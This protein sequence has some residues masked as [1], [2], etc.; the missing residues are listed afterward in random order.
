EPLVGLD[1]GRGD[2]DRRGS[3]DLGEGAGDRVAPQPRDAAGTPDLGA[4]RR[5][6]RV[7]ARDRPVRQLHRPQRPDPGFQS[8]MGYWP[9]RDTTIVV[10]TNLFATPAGTEPADEL[11]RL[12]IQ[13]LAGSASGAQSA[14]AADVVAL[15]RDAMATHDL[16]AVWV[17]GGRRDADW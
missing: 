6:A 5:R 13:A 1:G 4:D 16:R 14:Q 11:A 8:F 7:R 12:I 10:L 2:L 15:A 9:E 3:A 17:V